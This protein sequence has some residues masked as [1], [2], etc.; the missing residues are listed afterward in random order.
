MDI[1]KA[2]VVAEIDRLFDDYEAALL[3]NDLAALDRYFWESPATVRYGVVENLYGAADI[4][5]HRQRQ[6]TPVHPERRITRRV[7]T[8]F[9]ADMGTVSIEFS[10]PDTPR[11][12]RQMQTWVRFP[13]GWRIVAAHVSI[14]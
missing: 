11:I 2:A 6:W 10:A 3:R 5:A 1:N 14:P 13:E 12:G 9:G 7:T 8:T 4:R